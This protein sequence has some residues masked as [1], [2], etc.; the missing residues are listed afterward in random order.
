MLNLSFE[1]GHKDIWIGGSDGDPGRMAQQPDDWLI[2]ALPS[3]SPLKSTGVF[4]GDDPPVMEVVQTIPEVRHI[5][6]IDLPPEQQP[7]GSDAL[8]LGGDTCFKVFSAYSPFSFTMEILLPAEETGAKP[9]DTLDVAVP[10]NTHFH[11]YNPPDG[12]WGDGSL[13]ACRWRAYLVGADGAVGGGTWHTYKLNIEDREYEYYALS[14]EADVTGAATLCIDLESASQAGITYFVDEIEVDAVPAEP[15]PPDPPEGGECRGLPRTKYAKTTLLL[16]PRE[17][18]TALE[19]SELMG[20]L[21]PEA[22]ANGWQ[23]GFSADDAGVGDLDDITVIAISVHPDDW[24]KDALAA[25]YADHYPIVELMFRDEYTVPR[26]PLDMS[27]YPPRAWYVP[28]SV[29]YSAAHPAIDIN[30]DIAPWGD[31]ERGHPV[32]AVSAGDVHYWTDDWG[33]IGMMVVKHRVNGRDWWVQYA[34]ITRSGLVEGSHVD[35]GQALGGIAD[36][37][38]GDGGDHLHFG[39]SSTPVQREYLTHDGWVDPVAWLKEELGL[40]P[41]LV[42]AMVRKGDT[43]PD[44]DPDPEPPDIPTIALRSSNTIGLHSGEQRKNWPDYWTGAAPNGMKVF[45]CGFAMECRRL[46]SDPRAVVVWRRY[47]DND[48]AAMNDPVVL[49]DRYS[50]EIQAHAANTGMTETQVIEALGPNTGLESRN[51]RIPTFSPDELRR[52]VD[53]DVGFYEAVYSRYG[54]ALKAVGLTG[55]VGNPHETEVEIMLPAARAA[56]LYDGFVGY[57]AYWTA[58]RD[59]NYL[60][61]YWDIHAGRWCRWDDVFTANGIYPRYALGEGGIVYAPDGL[62]FNSG[63]GWRSCGTFL[64]YLQQMTTFRNLTAEWNA[65]NQNR[66]AMLTIFCHGNWGW[67][68]FEICEPGTDGNLQLMLAQSSAWV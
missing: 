27:K 49:L 10:V 28:D 52:V 22:H 66:C 20:R 30:L 8:I 11:P 34:H 44:P 54:A 59:R 21:L 68:D 64:E 12:P 14:V 25:F 46:V 29:N 4:P 17:K 32:T 2:S 55:A 1:N 37:T 24:D 18:I 15:D 53:Y 26:F 50:T 36:W 61:E 33:G 5:S 58:N 45:S 60:V 57:H 63:K 39:V 13:G 19:L 62:N 3:G 35:S 16:P 42:D 41:V 40:D 56:M 48:D 47:S 23:W 65:H 9:G 51:E 38:G 67:D 6:T 7:G 43:D 31:V